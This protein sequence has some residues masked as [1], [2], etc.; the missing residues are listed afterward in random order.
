MWNWGVTI[1]Y[2]YFLSHLLWFIKINYHLRTSS[3][4][5]DHKYLIELSDNY[6]Q[7]KNE[8]IDKSCNFSTSKITLTMVICSLLGLGHCTSCSSCLI[9]TDITNKIG[10]GFTWKFSNGLV[11]RKHFFRSVVM[12]LRIMLQ[13]QN[14]DTKY[15]YGN[16]LF[17]NS[18]VQYNYP[19]NG[20]KKSTMTWNRQSLIILMFNI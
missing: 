2:F 4:L 5:V 13:L 17:A 1:F 20:C 9:F 14:L 6:E 18:L 10:Q 3:I 8:S 12:K 16:T 19:F 15:A 7:S 11:T